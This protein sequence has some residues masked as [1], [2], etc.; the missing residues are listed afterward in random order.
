MWFPALLL[1]GKPRAG[2]RPNAHRGP[3]AQRRSFRPGLE[4][5]EDRRVLSTLTVLNN[6]DS[7][8]GSLRDTIAQAK[9]GDTIVF[10][11]SVNGQTITLTSGQL[12]IKKSLSIQGPGA[13]LLAISGN[14]T[15]RVF[16]ITN[17]QAVSLSGLTI[18]HG[19]A[20]HGGAILDEVGASLTLDG[21]TLSDNH[22]DGGLGGGAIFN[23]AHASL[24]ITGSLLTN[25]SASTEVN[26][27]KGRGGGGGGA[28]LNANGAYLSVTGSTLSDNEA[29]TREGF[30]N[31]GG[32]LYNLGGT[33]ALAGCT[34]ANNQVLG[35]GS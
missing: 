32:A 26:F 3:A 23:D 13:G 18:S 35:G 12:A 6:L 4:V 24:S 17:N 20:D 15:S 33:A 2:R 28:I 30:D 16:D 11:S 9:S 27:N 14:D 34:L 5:L 1:S 19:K 22:A 25:N 31:F 21:V 8:A 7:G 29:V 10:A